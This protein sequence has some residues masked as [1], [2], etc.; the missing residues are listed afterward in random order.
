MSKKFYL[1]TSIPYINGQPH[2]G[3]AW[4][5]VL[6][7][8]LARYKRTQGFDVQF[9]TG[10]DDNSLKNVQAAEKAG[11]AVTDLVNKNSNH[12]RQV[13][14]GLGVSYDDFIRTV[15]ERHQIGAQKLWEACSQ[16]IYKK[17]Y[18]GLYCVGCEEFKRETD[19]VNEECPEHPG[20]K[21]EQIEEE[22]YFFA[23]SKYQKKLEKLIESDDYQIFPQS[24]KNEVLSFI[25]QGLED[26]SIS[27]S[28]TRAKNWGIK[29]PGDDEQIIYVWFDALANYITALGYGEDDK[30]FEDFW[31]ADVHLVGKG[32]I[33]FH[34]IYWPAMLISA[35]LS[36]PKSLFVHGYL[37]IDGQKISKS[38][39]NTIDPLELVKKYGLDPVR[40]FLLKEN[41]FK[42]SDFTYERFEEKYNSD[43]A[44]DLGNLVQRSLAMV[45]K[46]QIK[47]EVISPA[48]IYLDDEVA[49]FRFDLALEAIWSQVRGLNVLIDQEKPWVLAKEDPER[50]QEV[51]NGV[52]EELW[53][54]AEAL[55]PFLPETAAKLQGQLEMLKPE[56]LFPRL[57][58]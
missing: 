45:N 38:L 29:V 35:G 55:V 5:F 58:E 53:G 2:I 56:P 23:L 31:P 51:L 30:K 27:R 40:Y 36:V 26:F 4:E 44:N 19:L 18:K 21:P 48:E 57:G 34:A 7:D 33:K 52:L 46:Y 37:T 16:D 6:A 50:L 49:D 20:E 17:K 43:L 8:A 10:T 41:P 54:I 13:I 24:R 1:T 22:N 14:D 32:I 47:P 28:V 3:H 42:D 11:V 25:R 15:E 12:F 9:L 39:G